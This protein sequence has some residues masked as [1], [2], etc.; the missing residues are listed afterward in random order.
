MSAMSLKKRPTAKRGPPEKPADSKPFEAG[1]YGVV[2]IKSGPSKG[3]L[4]YYDNDADTGREAVVYFG[5]P[6]KSDYTLVPY[7]QLEKVDVTLLDLERF[8]REHPE[9]ASILGLP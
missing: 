2:R 3:L 7:R 9:L 4:G 1:N 8:K 5:A 6:F